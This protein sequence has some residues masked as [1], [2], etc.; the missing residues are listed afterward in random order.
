MAERADVVVVGAGPTGAVTALGLAQRG[1]S[2]TVVEAQPDIVK[3]PRAP[4][5]HWSTLDGLESL[6]LLDAV[7]E[8]GF[9]KADYEFLQWETGA[10][11]EW[12]ITDALADRTAHPYNVHLGQHE[13]TRLALDALL[14]LPG[15]AVHFGIPIDQVTQLADGVVVSGEGADGRVE[16]AADWVIG[17]DGARSSVRK[18]LGLDFPGM[19][20]GERFVATNVYFDFTR[21]GWKRSVILSSPDYGAII[22]LITRDGLWRC[23]FAEDESL[24][25][26]GIEDRI[27]A[28]YAD[29][30]PDA[31]AAGYT[32]DA[33]QPYK[34]HQR[35]AETFRS[36]RV[37]LAGDAAHTTNPTGGYGL[38]MGMYDSFALVPALTAV[39][40]GADDEILDRWAAARRRLFLEKAS[41]AAVEAKRVVFDERDPERRRQDLAGYER[42]ASDPA[43]LRERLLSIDALR[44][45]KLEPRPA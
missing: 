37:L 32:I 44:G 27:A 13:L 10:R 36:G 38:T 5:Y 12:S 16:I 1:A 33:F 21:Y 26:E 35:A 18:S 11:V 43:V 39:L 3:A 23:T 19:T 9:R 41:P 15:T 4:V 28:Y 7:E 30:F 2:V 45:E 8:R 42:M 20:W 25:L 14:E 31:A 29:V 22:A 40:D 17:T 6:G 34:M 24:P